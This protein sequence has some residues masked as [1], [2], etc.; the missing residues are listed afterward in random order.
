MDLLRQ[1]LVAFRVTALGPYL[2]NSPAAIRG[3]DDLFRVGDVNRQ[4]LFAEHVF[5]GVE[6]RHGAFAMQ[7]VRQDDDHRV[8]VIILEHLLVV[9]VD[10]RLPGLHKLPFL[11]QHLGQ[12][13]AKGRD[14]HPF[15]I[16]ID[17]GD[18]GFA[19]VSA[20]ENSDPK[21]FA[22]LQA[23]WDNRPLWCGSVE[24]DAGESGSG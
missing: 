3:G 2:K 13:V 4:G 6:R 7:R 24:S 11:F 15:R 9:F 12:D 5:A 16:V 10:R 14:L 8:E 23:G 21:L 19:A 1:R 22:G 18:V 17:G 20:S